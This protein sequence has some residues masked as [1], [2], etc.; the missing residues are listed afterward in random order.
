MYNK[1]THGSGVR[2]FLWYTFNVKR[3]IAE[4]RYSNTKYTID[5][6][7]YHAF[8]SENLPNL[9]KNQSIKSQQ[10]ASLGQLKFKG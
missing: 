4:V 1:L 10:A 6:C 7:I 2:A 3:H 5:I 9:R 8:F